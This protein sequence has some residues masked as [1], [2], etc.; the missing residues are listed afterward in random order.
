MHVRV[1][2]QI[3]R[4]HVE[5]EHLDRRDQIGQT[6]VGEDAAVLGDQAVVQ[7]LQVRLE[8]VGT[9][10]GLGDDQRTARRRRS[11]QLFIGGGQT[12]IDAGQG[13]TIGFVCAVRRRVMGGVGQGLQCGRHLRQF[14][15]QAQLGAQGMNLIQIEVQ[16]SPRLG[17]EGVALHHCIHVRIA[18]AVA[19]DPA[20]DPHEGLEVRRIQQAPPRRQL[21]GRD[22][23]ED[24]VQEGDHRLDLVLHHQPLGPHQTRGPQNDDLAAQRLGDRAGRAGRARLVAGVQQVADGGDAV[25]HALAAHL[26]RVGGQDRRH[27]GL[28]QQVGHRRLVHALIGQ[29]L[30]GAFRRIGAG[31]R[32]GLVARAAA[33]GPVLGDVGQ[34]REQG[35][36]VRQ[37]CRLIHR[38]GGEQLLQ[39][40]GRMG[41]RVAV[42][43]DG[44]LTHGLDMLIQR[45]AALFSDHFA[46]NAPQQTDFVAQGV[47]GGGAH[48]CFNPRL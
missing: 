18:V 25:D 9:G 27:Q 8:G 33:A 46:Q 30:Q 35:E 13:A 14:G 37:P 39:P 1:L 34:K 17:A 42:I 29:T 10:I 23:Q 21:L 38:H 47:V 11:A 15:R 2:A 26:G 31:A 3:Q 12:G 7:H 48:H 24:A 5:A 36:A 41:R 16:H 6:V 32:L 43:G 28:T 45:L 20:A 40:L 44:G 4:G 22:V 19:P